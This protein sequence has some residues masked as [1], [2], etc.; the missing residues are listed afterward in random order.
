M[1]VPIEYFL[2]G[3][4]AFAAFMLGFGI[5]WP[6]IRWLEGKYGGKDER[7]IVVAP[8]PAEPAPAL[9]AEQPCGG[10]ASIITRQE[11]V[12]EA[13]E[14]GGAEISTVVHPEQ[15]HQPVSLKW[16]NKTYAMLYGTDCGIVMIIKLSNDY[17]AHLKTVHPAICRAHF[18]T[19]EN[20]Y[21]VHVDKEFHSKECVYKVIHSARDFVASKNNKD[22]GI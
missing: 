19:A 5:V 6:L 18:P 8:V 10:C 17:A 22:D 12:D 21:Y 4:I 7:T 3:L 11:I 16:H 14:S 9:P 20:W 15:L 13:Y 2:Y 1:P